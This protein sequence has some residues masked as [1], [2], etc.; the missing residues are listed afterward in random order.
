[1]SA[2]ALGRNWSL[3][4]VAVVLAVLLLA[5]ALPYLISSYYVAIATQVLF[6][7]LL[8]MSIDLL[9]G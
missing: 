7:G 9:G 1:M 3:P 6:F 4:A 5:L 8:A 2:R